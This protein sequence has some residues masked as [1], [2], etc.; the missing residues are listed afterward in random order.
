MIDGVVLDVELFDAQHFAE[1]MGAHERREAGVEAGLGLAVD[2]QQL[3]VAPEVFRARGDLLARERF[4]DR[5]VVVDDLQR[6]EAGL[7]DVERLFGVILAALAAL[8]TFNV[9]HGFSSPLCRRRRRTRNSSVL[10]WSGSSSS[11]RRRLG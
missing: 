1:A 9:A 2:R 11:W 10:R 4:L 5:V 3:A 6:T 7:A 8:Q